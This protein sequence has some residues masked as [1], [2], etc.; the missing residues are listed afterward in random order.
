MTDMSTKPSAL[1]I[2]DTILKN[3]S[4]FLVTDLVSASDRNGFTT[5]LTV[6]CEG[7]TNV[8]TANENRRYQV[9]VAS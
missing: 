4:E 9:K 5:T 3:G 7:R 1:R 2:G 6:T 8:W